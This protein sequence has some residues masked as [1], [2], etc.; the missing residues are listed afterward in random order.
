[1]RTGGL[2]CSVPDSMLVQHQPGPWNRA[3]NSCPTSLQ[4][5]ECATM[6]C[7]A[8]KLN[9]EYCGKTKMPFWLKRLNRRTKLLW[10]GCGSDLPAWC[11][12]DLP[13]YS[14]PE[15]KLLVGDELSVKIMKRL[16]VMLGT[17]CV[18]SPA[19]LYFA[20]AVVCGAVAH[21]HKSFLPSKVTLQIIN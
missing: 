3:S 8:L 18:T 4:P 17:S 12:S 10:W 7:A 13:P 9:S 6:L 19:V 15:I 21:F 1:M 20:S 5:S 2:F 11:S 14:L 16:P